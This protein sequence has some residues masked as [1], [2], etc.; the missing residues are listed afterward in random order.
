MKELRTMAETLTKFVYKGD[1]GIVNIAGLDY[2][3]INNKEYFLPA[4]NA[5][6]KQFVKQGKLV[7]ITQKKVEVK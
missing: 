1:F 3:L 6:V 5:K 7:Y 4:D 2:S